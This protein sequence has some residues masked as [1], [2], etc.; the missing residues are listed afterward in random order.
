MFLCVCLIHVIYIYSYNDYISCNL[1]QDRVAVAVR[2]K[3]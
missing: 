2:A 1:C 3:L